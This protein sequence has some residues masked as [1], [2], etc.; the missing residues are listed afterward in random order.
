MDEIRERRRLAEACGGAE[1]VARHHAAG[2]LTVRERIAA[3]L[4]ADSFR[5]VGKLAGRGTYDKA[6]NLLK[7]EPAAYVMG[8]GR[9]DGRPVAVGGEDYTIRAG[10][11]FGSD[12]RKGGQG[13]FIED[14]A[15]EYRIPLV[16][17]VDGTGGTVSTARRKG[18]TVVPGYG[19]DGFERSVDLMEVVPVVSAVMGTTAGGPSARALLCH[20]SIMVR[21]TSQIFA[22]GPPV[23]ERAF[24]QQITKEALGGAKVAADIAGTI[25]NVADSE[26]ECLAQIRRFLSYL[27]TNVWELPPVAARDDPAERCEEELAAIVPRSARQPYDMRRLIELIADRGSVFEIQE[28]FGRAVI[29]QLARMNGHVVGIIGNNPRFGGIMDYKA[30]RKQGHFVELC[31]MFNIPLIFFVDLPGFMVGAESEASAMLREGVRARFIGLQVSVPVFTVIVRKCY[32]MAGGGA[33]D[34]RGLNFK[35]AWP[36]AEWGSLPVE[37]GVKA[38]YKREIESAPD[39]QQR[40]RELEEELRQLASP[41]RTAEA[42]AVEDLIDPRETRPYLC[43]FIE[44]LQPRLKTQLGPKRKGGVRP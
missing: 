43:Q 21:G 44:A 17:L 9:I 11:G 39:P 5:E 38:A 34:R 16:N 7:F 27:P 19:Q 41:L 6:G 3:L 28:T 1:A 23:V 24:G 15:Y 26:Q 30:A 8:I 18:Y 31:D 13:G 12:R 35:I 29:T 22:A 33:I 2:K 4:D 37:G 32:G 40:E 42:F 14:L 25:D 20:W 10:T 36:S